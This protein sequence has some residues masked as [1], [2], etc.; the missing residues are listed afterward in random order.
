[1]GY[2]PD[3]GYEYLEVNKRL[4]EVHPRVVREVVAA[5]LD[6]GDSVVQ[7]K[8]TELFQ[9]NEEFS[10]S[11]IIARCQRT[12]AGA[13]RWG[14]RLDRVLRPDITVAVRMDEVNQLP[15]DYYLLP[16][17]DM[18]LPKLRLA[19]QNGLHFDAYR[20]DTLDYLYGMARRARIKEA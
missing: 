19:E 6:L 16:T 10:V 15:M 3:R 9:V 17:I 1:M 8:E 7:D 4:R 18:T 11:L 12:P 2:E 13:Y 5:M 14:I 20:F